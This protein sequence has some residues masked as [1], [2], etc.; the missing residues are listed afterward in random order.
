MVLFLCFKR[1]ICSI[2]VDEQYQAF[3]G[4]ATAL[5]RVVHCLCNNRFRPAVQTPRFPRPSTMQSSSVE[6]M[7]MPLHLHQD[8]SPPPPPPRPPLPPLCPPPLCPPSELAPFV[9]PPPRPSAVPIVS[10][11]VASLF[12]KSICVRIVFARYDTTSTSWMWLLLPS[13]SSVTRN[14]ERYTH[15]SLSI[16]SGFTFG[17]KASAF[18]RN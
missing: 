3:N 16:S 1:P 12:D 8:L 9:C 2:V 15:K 18:S 13:I 5:F 10:A 11:A 17:A 7:Q 6:R 4:P 14:K